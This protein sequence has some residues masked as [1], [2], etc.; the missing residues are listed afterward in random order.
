MDSLSV[1]QIQNATQLENVTI[2]EMKEAVVAFDSPH[3]YLV[4]RNAD[5][6]SPEP[7]LWIAPKPSAPEMVDGAFVIPDPCFLIR[8][9]EL[10]QSRRVPEG[11]LVF[12]RPGYAI[13]YAIAAGMSDFNVEPFSLKSIKTS[14]LRDPRLVIDHVDG[15]PHAVA[16][17]R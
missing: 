6:F 9:P 8:H 16:M 3:W 7:Y 10:S 4:A 17:L 5:S 11:L 1:T 14:S 12:S 2:D 13:G 15:R